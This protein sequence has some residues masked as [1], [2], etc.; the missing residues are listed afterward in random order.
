MSVPYCYEDDCPARTPEK[1]WPRSDY[2]LKK[3]KPICKHC[4]KVMT[5]TFSMFDEEYQ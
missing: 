4:G 5:W 3:G 2:E 1:P